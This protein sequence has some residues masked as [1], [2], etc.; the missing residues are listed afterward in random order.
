MPLER[1]S[2]KKK[3]LIVGSGILASA[4]LVTLGA[5]SATRYAD[6]PSTNASI[7]VLTPTQSATSITS[8]SAPTVATPSATE[9]ISLSP[10]V[11]NPDEMMK[12]MQNSWQTITAESVKVQFRLE[13][14]GAR[15]NPASKEAY[16]DSMVAAWAPMEKV[17]P[18]SR[19]E[20]EAFADWCLLN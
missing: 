18:V 16:I 13:W 11:L 15:M 1:G 4:S 9:S 10:Y 5:C 3:I 14:G 17:Q 6:D 20:W 2:F 8:A 7:V 19:A 12:N